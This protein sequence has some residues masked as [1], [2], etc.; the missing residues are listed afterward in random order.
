[1][2]VHEHTIKMPC[3][4]LLR[5][6]LYK[7]IGLE[8]TKRDIETRMCVG[9]FIHVHVSIHE[10]LKYTFTASL[11]MQMYVYMYM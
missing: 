4:T 1:M 3:D 11:P 8:A 9:V 5:F 7:L 6:F 10:T 2:N